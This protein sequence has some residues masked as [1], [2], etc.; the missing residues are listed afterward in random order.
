MARTHIK[1]GILNSFQSAAA[2]ALMGRTP[3]TE[4]LWL[5]AAYS[6]A[7]WLFSARQD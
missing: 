3:V 4:A 7:P 1:P 5:R 6:S 2:G